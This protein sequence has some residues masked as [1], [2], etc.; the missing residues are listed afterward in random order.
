MMSFKAFNML[1]QESYDVERV[2]HDS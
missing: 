2:D 1:I